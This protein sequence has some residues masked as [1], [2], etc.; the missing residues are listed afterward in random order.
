VGWG[1]GDGVA[2]VSGSS[3]V[4]SR[5]CLA[6]DQ[7][8]REFKT[9]CHYVYEHKRNS[10]DTYAASVVLKVTCSVLGHMYEQAI[11]RVFRL[12]PHQES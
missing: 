4:Y 3:L 11:Y 9:W 12:S 1:G 6:A 2:T 10:M 8:G 5:V 7:S